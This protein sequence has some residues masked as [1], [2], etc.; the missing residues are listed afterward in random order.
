MGKWQLIDNL[1]NSLHYIYLKYKH[2]TLVLFLFVLFFAIS[3]SSM[4]FTDKVVAGVATQIKVSYDGKEKSFTATQNTIAGAMEQGNIPF[5]KYD[6]TEP[7]L[8][9][10]LNGESIKVKVI[11]ALP[12]LISDNNQ[13]HLAYSAYTSEKDILKQLDITVYPEDKVS[14]E[15]ITDPVDENAVG[16]KVIIER[17]P[18]YTV[19]VD[20]REIL[21]RSWSTNSKEVIAKGKIALGPQDIISPSATSTLTPGQ[22][23]IVTRINEFDVSTNESIEYDTI[24]RTSSNIAFG[25]SVV[26]QAGING[27]MKKTYHVVYKNGAEVE[28]TLMGS[29]VVS[30]KQDKIVTSGVIIGRAN[31]GYYSGMVT[32]FYKGMTGRYLLVT[33]LANGKQVK[34]KIL[35]SGPFNGPLMDMGTEPFQAIGGSLSSGYIPSVSVQLVD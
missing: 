16:Q 5:G 11:R 15:L 24:N 14:S 7:P 35:G 29:A 30:P 27:T 9:T 8:D 13:E 20:G 2:S 28:R 19:Q 6:I 18:V 33:N 32:S 25:K 21:V 4:V 22:D 23:I 34:V 10:H 1:I 26:T 12:V 3:C 17:A 31:F